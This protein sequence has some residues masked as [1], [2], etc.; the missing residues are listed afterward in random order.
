MIERF[1]PAK[2]LPLISS[3][4]RALGFGDGPDLRVLPA[5]GFV[6]DGCVVGFLYATDSALA[7]IEGLLSDPAAPLTRRRAAGDVLLEALCAEAKHL[8]YLRVVGAPSRRSL[9]N[10]MRRH[11]FKVFDGRFVAVREV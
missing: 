5:T 11:G 7:W 3:W 2:H 10:S 1:D 4:H 8:G 6:A 9:A